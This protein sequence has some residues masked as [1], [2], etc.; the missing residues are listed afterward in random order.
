MKILKQQHNC[1]RDVCWH[2]Y[3]NE[4][5]SSSWDRTLVK[6]AYADEQEPA[7]K[8]KMEKKGAKP[9]KRLHMFSFLWALFISYCIEV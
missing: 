8:D 1:V 3:L 4:L 9:R 7:I 5:V 2:P 6:W